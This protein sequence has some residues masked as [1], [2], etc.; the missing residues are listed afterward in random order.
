M[1]SVHINKLAAAKRQI[2]A[3]IRMSFAR[4]DELAIH[5]VAAAAYGL[6]KDIKKARGMSEAADAFL[7]T[8]F[9]LVRDYHRRTLPLHM[10][11]DESFMTEVKYLADQLS[12]ITAD[13]KLSD[14]RASVGPTVERHYW[15]DTNRAANFLKHADRDT[16]ESLPL[17]AID[18]HLLLIKC[19][20]AY[21]DV[22]PDDLGHEGAVFQAF[23]A[24]NNE[25]YEFG[26][27]SF[28]S[29]VLSMRKVPKENQR[30]LCHKL[31]ERLNEGGD[32]A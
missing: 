31:I 26:R 11:S 32:V 5:T 15:S 19:C 30:E 3:A 8:I 14:V 13:S 25:A 21:R 20:C 28:D 4:E 27:G 12:P 29:L 9:Y 22:A 10:T 23:V 18:N 24:A 2:Q 16:D 6:L 17:K 7:T 1:A